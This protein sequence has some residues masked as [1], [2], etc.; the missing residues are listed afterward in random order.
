[1][2]TKFGVTP[3]LRFGFSLAAL[4]IPLLYLVLRKQSD[5]YVLYPLLMGGAVALILSWP[6]AIILDDTGITQR[7][8]LGR[9]HF[10][11]WSDVDSVSVQMSANTIRVGGKETEIVHSQLHS[12]PQLFV[13]DVEA[14]TGLKHFAGNM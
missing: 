9:K 2:R 3:L 4:S 10:L 5:G 12:K 8:R 1:M 14:R 11:A 6:R 13:S 7:D